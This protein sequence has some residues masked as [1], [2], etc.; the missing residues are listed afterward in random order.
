MW[1]LLFQIFHL[2]KANFLVFALSVKNILA[3][4]KK[5]LVSFNKI[6]QLWQRHFFFSNAL[7]LIVENF[8]FS[9]KLYKFHVNYINLNFHVNYIM[10]L[11]LGSTCDREVKRGIVWSLVSFVSLQNLLSSAISGVTVFFNILVSSLKPICG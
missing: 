11:V 9:C 3:N 7:C 4:R 6:P 2:C 10:R 1:W 5:V 8:Y